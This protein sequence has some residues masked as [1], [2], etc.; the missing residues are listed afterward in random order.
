MPARNRIK[1]YVEGGFY[2]V[3]NRGVNRMEIFK[4]ERDEG[5]FLSYLKTYLLDK[6]KEELR[7]N[8][9]MK[10]LALNNF[11][12]RI[13][14]VAYCL[15]T[16][17]YHFLIR[18]EGV[19]DLTSFMKSLMTRYSQYFNKRYRRVGPIFQGRYKAVLVE[20][21]EQLNHLSRYIHLNPV[22]GSQQRKRTVLL[23]SRPSSYPNFLREVNQPWIK[24]NVVLD[25]FSKFGK[26]SYKDFVEDIDAD[27]NDQT[28]SLLK[29]LA[30]DP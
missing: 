4:D 15:M 28:M 7:K 22:M 23:R 27:L 11:F 24:P 14:L 3:Y 21:E 26:G 17:H 25:Y 10:E 13:D 30:I 18:Q 5:V 6:D 16:N 2:H 19:E 1:T 9:L 29:E 8:K 12:S 20:S